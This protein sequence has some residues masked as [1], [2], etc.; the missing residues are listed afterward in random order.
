M[1]TIHTKLLEAVLFP[2]LNTDCDEEFLIVPWGNTFRHTR[3]G[4]LEDFSLDL[5]RANLGG[6]TPGLVHF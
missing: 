3:K 4:A 6:Q 5:C 1:G 2:E